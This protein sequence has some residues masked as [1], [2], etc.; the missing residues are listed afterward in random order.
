M[1]A[2]REL[3]GHVVGCVGRAVKHHNGLAG[4]NRKLLTGSWSAQR[5]DGSAVSERSGQIAVACNNR[6]ESVCPSCA[7]RYAGDAYQ[8]VKSGLSGGKGVPDDAA[9]DI[10][11][12]VTLTAPSFGPVHTRSVTTRGRVRRCACGESHHEADTRIGSP[13]DVDSY[14][15]AG[16][17]LWNAHAGALWH[18][19]RIY[20]ARLVAACRGVKVKDIPHTFRL[21][22]SKV[23]EYQR[24]GL[25]HFH[26]V[27]RLD[28]PDGPGS[29]APEGITADMLD[30]F[31]RVSAW[32]TSV[33][34]EATDAYPATAVKWGRQVQVDPITPSSDDAAEALGDQRVAGYVAKYS[35]KGTGATAG[36][37]P[38][39]APRLTSTTWRSRSTT[40][41]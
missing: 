7:A 28:G 41:A 11:L 39:F 2:A 8:L 13:L 37:A 21:S 1:D 16:A 27:I 15:Y 20:L 14:D 30:E 17:V 38:G 24:R 12:F 23:A 6:R 5:R 26:A 4:G 32:K 35:T 9:S 19:F 34:I 36:T 29:P 31:I 18:R 22:Y 10:R 3:H 33:D 25:V 40:G